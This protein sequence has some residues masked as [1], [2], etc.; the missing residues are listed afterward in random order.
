MLIINQIIITI[1]LVIAMILLYGRNKEAI[2]KGLAISVI[3]NSF[4]SLFLIFFRNKIYLYGGEHGNTFWIKYSL[5]AIGVSFILVVIAM[6]L[7]GKIH[8]EKKNGKWKI[9]DYVLVLVGILFGFLNGTLI[10]VPTWFNKTFGEIPADH[11]IFLITQGNGESTKAQD[12]EIFNSMMVPVIMTAIIGGLVGF[13]RSNLVIENFRNDSK[14]GENKY[15]FK[16]TKLVAFILLL[17]MFAGSV[18]YAFKTIPLRDIIKLQFEKSTYV[19]DNYV[20]PTSENV[21]MPKKKR[22][23]IHIWMESVENSYYSKELGG[24]DDKNLMPDLVKLSDSGVSFSHTDKHGG[25][26]QTYASGHS[27]AGMVNMNSGVPMLAAGMRNGS[28]LSYPDFPTIGDILKKNGYETEFILGSD[29]KWGGLGDYY[30]KHGDFKIFDLVYAREQKLIPEN[31]KVWWGFEDDKLY[32]YAKDEMNKLA[33]SDKPFYLIIENADTHF[34]NG[35]VSKNMKDKPFEM[36]YANVIHYS[37]KETVKLVQWIQQQEWYKD[38]TIV[39]TG[40]HKSMDKKFFEGW[41]PQYNRTIVNMF[42][43]SIHGNDLPKEIT[44]N[45]MFAPFDMFPTIL[46]SIGVEIKDNRLGMGTDLF[47]GDKTLLEKDGLEKVETELP[48]RS[49]F[50]DSHR[51]S[52]ATK[53]DKDD[54][55]K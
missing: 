22:N 16:H 44:N 24:Y 4:S 3:A 23:L 8:L 6:L 36:Q 32:E 9:L 52:W 14:E 28:N 47:S 17:S 45:R 5:F 33:K 19:G 46:S 41:D 1:L 21:K 25:P 7:E 54:V 11:F 30:K 2:F 26:Q 12:L 51:E 42:L 39:V 31:Y 43:N 10:F 48:K 40:D 18:V 55:Y 27:I 35:Y 50:Y 34:P 53:Q 13:V 37:Q 38:T 49:E 15:I 20:M 29:S